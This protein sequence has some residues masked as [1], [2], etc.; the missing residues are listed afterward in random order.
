MPRAIQDDLAAQPISRQRKWQLRKQ[1]A[2][3]CKQCGKQAEDGHVHCDVCLDIC[4]RTT[5]AARAL[6][7]AA[8]R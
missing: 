7:P 2:G 6:N 1:R 4:R 5:A 3:L 8:R